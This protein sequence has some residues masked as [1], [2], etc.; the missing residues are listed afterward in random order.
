M[1]RVLRFKLRTL[2]AVMSDRTG[3]RV[4]YETINAA[5]GIAVSALSH[6]ANNKVTRLD[7]STIERLCEFFKCDL[8]DLVDLEDRDPVQQASEEQVSLDQAPSPD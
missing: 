6:V 5:T 8:T 7:A 4:T 1:P 3:Q 2:M